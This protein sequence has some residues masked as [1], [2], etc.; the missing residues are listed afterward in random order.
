M[1][2]DGEIYEAHKGALMRFATAL[3]GP[4]EAPDVVSQVVVRVL[5][6]RRLG[7]LR[8]PRPYLMRAVLNESRSLMRRR[9]PSL[10]VTEP[11]L[12][13]PEPAPEVL[14]AVMDLPVRQR[15]A[16]FL[17]YWAGMTPSEAARVMGARAG[18][19]RRYLHLARTRLGRVLDG[20]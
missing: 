20:S 2:R 17:V 1:G 14:A 6:R 10:L 5:S 12:D 15:A 18:T 8:D 4:D 9:R 19:I 7:D 11:V 16:I 3:V 13:S